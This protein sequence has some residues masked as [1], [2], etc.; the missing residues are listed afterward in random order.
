MA[1]RDTL[2][3]RCTCPSQPARAELWRTKASDRRRRGT[4]IVDS[5]RGGFVLR[6]ADGSEIEAQAALNT[7]GRRPNT[8]GLGLAELGVA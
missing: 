6:R 4:A 7:T 3:L 5:H 8:A 1:Y 2:P